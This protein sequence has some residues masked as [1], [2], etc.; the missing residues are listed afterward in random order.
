MSA[1][2]HGVEALDPMTYGAVALLLTVFALLSSYLPASRA[3]RLDPNIAL[4]QD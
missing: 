2:L 4:R 1:L 3:A